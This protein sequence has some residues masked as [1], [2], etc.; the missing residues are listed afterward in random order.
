[1]S[2]E[3][4]LDLVLENIG[5]QRAVAIDAHR[6]AR[7]TPREAERVA[8]SLRPGRPIEERSRIDDVRSQK[9]DQR[10]ASQRGRA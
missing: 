8:T 7:E 6:D 9:I 10:V 2:S 5:E 3:S 1:L 4:A